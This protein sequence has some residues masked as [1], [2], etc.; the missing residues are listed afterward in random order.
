[1]V[2]YEKYAMI[3]SMLRKITV[4]ELI[5]FIAR[6]IFG[7]FRDSHS[8]RISMLNRGRNATLLDRYP[9]AGKNEKSSFRAN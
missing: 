5:Y 2:G 8:R 6:N 1:M 4:L 9:F 3:K 7:S